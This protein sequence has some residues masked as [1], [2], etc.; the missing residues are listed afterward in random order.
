MN[1]EFYGYTFNRIYFDNEVFKQFISNGKI[2]KMLVDPKDLQEAKD[3]W[4]TEEEITKT[5]TGYIRELRDRKVYDF[6]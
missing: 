4:K 5:A 1:K 6:H 2:I 3:F